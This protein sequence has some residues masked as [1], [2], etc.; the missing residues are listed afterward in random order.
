ME[1]QRFDEPA[2]YAAR[3]QPFLLRAPARHNLYLGLLDI[4]MRHPA[5]YPSFHLWVVADG[6]DVTAAAMQT[7]PHNVVLAEPVASEAIEAIVEAIVEAGLR[8]PGVV[9][10]V[11]EARAFADAWRAHRGGDY[12]TINR[13]GIYELTTV[14]EPGPA[15]GAPRLATEEDLPLLLDWHADFIAEAVPEHVGADDA[16]RRRIAGVVADDGSWFWEADGE[17][18]S[19]TGA[20]AAPPVGTRIGPV[21]TPPSLRGRGYATALVAHVSAHALAHGSTRCYLHTDL[22]NPTSNAIYQRI[23]YEWVCEATEIRFMPD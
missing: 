11:T 17:P 6:D 23:G 8:P 12:R 15:D 7:P 9:G 16:M 14:C 3:V 10:G 13:Q 19:M 5:T 20:S 21:Y 1:V 22:A 4:L 2:A 18:V